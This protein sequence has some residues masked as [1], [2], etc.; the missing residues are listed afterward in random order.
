MTN[1]ASTVLIT[2][3]NRGIGLE[4]ARQYLLEGWRVIAACR[5]PERAQQLQQLAGGSAGRLNT[6][7]L[8]VSAASSVAQAAARLANEPLDLLLNCAGIMGGARQSLGQID[9][10]DWARVLEV[11]TLGP[12]RVL[13]AFRAH[14]ERSARRVAVTLTSGMGSITENTSGGWVAYRTSKAALN[15]AMKCAALE[16]AARRIVCVV[17]HP[18]WVRTDMG[19][20]QAPLSPTESVT[21]MRRVIAALGSEDSG[22]F[23]NYDGRDY[24]W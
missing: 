23:L 17:M 9:Y 21:A 24:P 7:A 4:F 13:E 1:T 6:L 19:G 8:D 10:A 16:L 2:G 14:L 12:V 11:N 22:K 15:M 5:T 20:A 18:G 3:A